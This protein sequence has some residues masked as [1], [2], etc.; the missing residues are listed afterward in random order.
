MTKGDI[1]AK[2]KFYYNK[3][4]DKQQPSNVYDAKMEEAARKVLIE[5]LGLSAPT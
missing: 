2:K 3:K 4:G 5:Q 1:M